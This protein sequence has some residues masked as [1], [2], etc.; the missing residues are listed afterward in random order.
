[1]L[2]VI[3][4][5][6]NEPG[7]SQGSRALK[8]PMQEAVVELPLCKEKLF[9]ARETLFQVQGAHQGPC[10]HGVSQAIG[11]WNHFR[12]LQMPGRQRQ[13]WE[14]QWRVPSGGGWAGVIV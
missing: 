11:K 1:M 12:K 13:W 14:R 9:G 8:G 6:V 5:S 3:N 4:L 7:V 2:K 10:P